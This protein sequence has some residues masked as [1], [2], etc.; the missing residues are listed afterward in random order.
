MGNSFLV[1]LNFVGSRA[2][3]SIES[4][5]VTRAQIRGGGEGVQ[6]VLLFLQSRMQ[7]VMERSW[8]SFY[9]EEEDGEQNVY[10]LV[11]LPV[12]KIEPL[13]L[14]IYFL[15]IFVYQNRINWVPGEGLSTEDDGVYRS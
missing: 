2:D 4:R 8:E 11:K 15:I 6:E 7:H 1:G 9:E 5:V 14:F 10:Y 13:L 3:L 12:C